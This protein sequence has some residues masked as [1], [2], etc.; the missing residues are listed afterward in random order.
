V[1]EKD[2]GV[3]EHVMMIDFSGSKVPW[4]EGGREGRREARRG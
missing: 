1:R 4:R 2:P 3:G